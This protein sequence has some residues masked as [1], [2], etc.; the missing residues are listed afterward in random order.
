MCFFFFFSFLFCYSLTLS[1]REMICEFFFS[2]VYVIRIPNHRIDRDTNKCKTSVKKESTYMNTWDIGL[3]CTHIWKLSLDKFLIGPLKIIY[4]IRMNKC[5]FY[6]SF[7]L[8]RD[9]CFFSSF[10]RSFRVCDVVFWACLPFVWPYLTLSFRHVVRH[11]LWLGFDRFHLEE[12]LWLSFLCVC[13]FFV[14]FF[15][16]REYF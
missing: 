1:T 16:R 3:L 15:L 8:C 10:F 14:S 12:F 5:V 7:A 2:L 11:K 4:T 9:F 13:D 6:L